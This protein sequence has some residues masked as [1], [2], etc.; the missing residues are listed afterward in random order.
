M[1]KIIFQ[2]LI[3]ISTGMFFVFSGVAKL[4]PIEIFEY[5]F[6]ETKIIGWKLAPVVARIFISFEIF[7]G[8]LVIFQF[9]LKKITLP[10]VFL[11]LL[12]FIAYL[13][14]QIITEGNQGNCG[15]FGKQIHFTPLEA[16]VKNIV[17]I[18]LIGIIYKTNPQ[19]V[20]YKKVWL[21]LA[22]L[23]CL[24]LPFILNPI[25]IHSSVYAKALNT[26][27]ELDLLYHDESN[28]PPEVDIREGKWVVV[29]MSASCAH[30]KVTARKIHTIVNVS[31]NLPIY[32]V[33]NGDD[34]EIKQFVEDAKINNVK[35]SK[36]N[37]ATNFIKLAGITLPAIYFV[38]NSVL[39]YQL[40]MESLNNQRIE[41]WLKN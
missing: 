35:W 18:I 24:A 27:I 14:F 3:C 15:C 13:V 26:K 7:C 30:C 12:F 11:T 31:P 16:I 6:I 38:E 4:F 29:F 39:H 1:S 40:D 22:V 32:L 20:N 9:R 25:V 21:T 8:L 19:N 10:I 17:M 28:S 37:G 33:I 2:N 23:I 36:F 34:S 5:A 41:E